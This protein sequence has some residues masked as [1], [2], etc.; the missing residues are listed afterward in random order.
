MNLHLV[1][2]VQSALISETDEAHITFNWL[3]L[4]LKPVY[5]CVFI[6]IANGNAAEE[7]VRFIR[8][9]D[10]LFDELCMHGEKF[11]RAGVQPFFAKQQHDGLQPHTDVGPLRRPHAAVK[12]AQQH[13][14]G[15]E[16]HYIV[17]N[18]IAARIRFRATNT[19]SL[20]HG[21]PN[22]RQAGFAFRDDL[23]V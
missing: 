19:H 22:L 20:I 2:G 17:T 9:T 12:I 4:T 21:R 16:R 6:T 10:K 13:S 18:E 15:I 3:P 11:L 7:D 1:R 5:R 8:H 23:W 14:R